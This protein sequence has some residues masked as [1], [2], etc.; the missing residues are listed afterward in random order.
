LTQVLEKRHFSFKRILPVSSA[1]PSLFRLLKLR[2]QLALRR[3]ERYSL[4]VN[5]SFAGGR[6]FGCASASIYAIYQ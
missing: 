2:L 1:T 5:D 3:L 4:R 6:S